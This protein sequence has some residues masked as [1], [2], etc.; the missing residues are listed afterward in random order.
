MKHKLF[1]LSIFFAS[2]LTFT[3]VS[4]SRINAAQYDR[5]KQI[6]DATFLNKN[7]MSE[8]DINNFINQFPNS[9]LRQQNYP[10]NLSTISFKEPLSY[11][12]YGTDVSPARIIWKASQLWGINPQVILATLEKEQ[13]FVTGN[14]GCATWRYNSVMGYNCPDTLKL[15][16]YPNINIS[17]TCVE[18][19]AD[20][21][22]SRQIN[23]GAWQLVFN[24]ERSEGNLSWGNNSSITYVGYMTQGYRKRSANS[25]SNYYDGYAT[26]DGTS[27]YISNGAT[28]S[29]YSYTPHF[30]NFSKIFYGWFND[31]SQVSTAPKTLAS[32]STNIVLPGKGMSPGEFITSPNGSFVLI[33]QYTGQL[34][35]YQSGQIIWQSGTTYDS[36]DNSSLK[37]QDDGN[38]VLYTEGNDAPTWTSNTAG[39]GATTLSLQNDGN[40]VLYSPTKAVW[41]SNTDVSKSQSTYIDT[42][43]PRGGRLKKGDY[44]R[45]SNWK[46]FLTMQEN[47]NL[48]LKTA[49]G[50]NTLWQTNTHNKGA[51]YVSMQTDGNLVMYTSNGKPVWASDTNNWGDSSLSLQTD[52]N[53]V[54]Y[55]SASKAVWAS[56]TNGKGGD[57]VSMQTDGNLVM[58]TPSGKAVWASDTNGRRPASTGSSCTKTASLKQTGSIKKNET[59]CSSDNNYRLTMQTDGNLVMYMTT[60]NAPWAT[61]TDGKFFLSNLGIN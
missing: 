11:S 8:Q 26:I 20:A 41:A 4:S 37:L 17:R 36:K 56:D 42:K 13:N 52:G 35:L 27:V 46:Y 39:S 25:S 57:S 50:T 59:L 60:I 24:K 6:E 28:A 49:G 16:D 9:C 19:E 22:L 53:L 31:S 1:I 10:N 45:S 12:N 38:L 47:G 15:S 58:Y 2:I 44:L 40:L 43:L 51:E 55:T 5:S 48:A 33:M 7:A 18:R 32:L 54:M 21:G 23:H 34:I 61:N 29:L 3:L 14:G 30:S